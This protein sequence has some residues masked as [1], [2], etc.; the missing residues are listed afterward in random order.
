MCVFWYLFIVFF[1]SSRRR[2]T[3]CALVTGVQTCALPILNKEVV[4]SMIKRTLKNYDA[5]NRELSPI[6]Q[7]W[8]E[9]KDFIV[10][11]LRKTV[12]HDAEFLGYIA[13]RTQNWN[14][15]RIALM[16]TILMKMHFCEV[17]TF[18][19]ILRWKVRRVWKEDV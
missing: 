12:E 7:N 10:T 8:P 13:A 19:E 15:E 6:S 4:R 2:H 3:R 5:G 14:V 16:D 11:L 9:D 1:F 18:P 17:L